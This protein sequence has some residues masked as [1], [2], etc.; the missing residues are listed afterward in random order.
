MNPI[1][2]SPYSGAVA[3]VTRLSFPRHAPPEPIP[4]TLQQEWAWKHFMQTEVPYIVHDA[5]RLRGPL[6]VDVLCRSLGLVIERHESLRTRI[7][8]VDGVPQQ[9]IDEPS[10]FGLQIV[11]FGETPGNDIEA[12][13]ASFLRSFFGK[14]IDLER[15]P[16]FD[17]RLLRLSGQDHILAMV[18]HHLLTDSV[19]FNLLLRELWASYGA[20][21][22]GQQPALPALSMQYGDYALW[23]RNEHSRWLQKHGDYWR[24][25]LASAVRVCLPTDKGLYDVRS[26]K[27][28]A[29]TTKLSQKL[30][31]ALHDLARRQRV[32]TSTV[33]LSLH[34]ILLSCWSGQRNFA[35]PY[36]VSGRLGTRDL[37]I[38]GQL[39]QFLVLRIELAEDTTFIQVLQLLTQE[40]LAAYTHLDFGKVI[41]DRSDL[42][43]GVAL[44]G[45]MESFDAFSRNTLRCPDGEIAIEFFPIG[46]T[47]PDEFRLACDAYL[48][49]WSADSRICSCCHYRA[50]RFTV[51]TMQRFF[52]A[53]QLIAEQVAND[54]TA[55]VSTLYSKIK[56]H[57]PSINARAI[58]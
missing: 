33:M 50:D 40:F 15:G 19:S 27:A 53:L 57:V 44:S 47:M 16:L 39:G 7:V 8:T 5:R 51:E 3:A 56:E 37:N 43:T 2:P 13:A 36:V 48:I 24:G 11:S 45:V 32:T 25:R 26:N 31:R 21:C 41:S 18:H 28:A 1:V 58:S 38:I 9:Q 30:S 23:Q 49:L 46:F 52:E 10:E 14:P 35:I 17:V 55:R 6:S 4:L 12:H 54:P 20:L 42:F 22:R 29:I 34:S